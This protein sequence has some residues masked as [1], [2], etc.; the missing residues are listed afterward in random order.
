MG[1]KGLIND[2]DLDGSY[3]INEG[4]RQARRLL[5]DINE[6]GMP[7][8]SEFLS[9]YIPHY[10]GDL[11]SWVAIGARTAESQVHRE[12]ASGLPMPVGFKNG[13]D[14]NIDVAVD[15]VTAAKAR[16]WFPTVTEDG[17]LVILQTS[18]N[19]ACHVVLRGGT[20]SGP[21]YDASHVA[22][23]SAQ[24]AA[25]HLPSRVMVDCSHDNSGKDYRRQAEVAVAVSAQLEAGSHGILGVMLESHLVDGRQDHATGR[26]LVHGQS[27]TDACISFE[28]TERLLEQFRAANR[29]GRAEA[30][31]SRPTA[32]GL[33]VRRDTPA[34]RGAGSSSLAL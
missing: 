27:I 15:A 3:R 30:A 4:L 18:G 8:G 34:L 17:L 13:T 29:R 7:T 19:D 1:W 28:Q 24:L 12:I 14:G 11:T 6:M 21:N 31:R 32:P 5:L 16:H 26:Q 25:R 20:R 33:A 22:C 23:V 10:V 2:P 9:P